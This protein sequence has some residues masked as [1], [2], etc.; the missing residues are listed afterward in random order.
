MLTVTGL[1]PSIRIFP[2][3]RLIHMH[4]C[5]EKTIFLVG[6]PNVGKS[7]IFNALTGLREHT[8]N[9]S[10][11][12]ARLSRG[13]FLY[14]DGLYH[15]VDLPGVYSLRTLSPEEAL[16]RS[17]LVHDRNDGIVLVADATCLERNL[18][19]I[20]QVLSLG[21]N[22][23]LCLNLMDEARKRGIQIDLASLAEQLG[24]PVLAASAKTGEGLEMLLPEIKA[25]C[26]RN[27][28]ASE[29]AVSFKTQASLLDTDEGLAPSLYEKAA[30]IYR[31][32]VKAKNEGPSS[33]DLRL[34]RLLTRPLTAYPFMAGLL[35]LIFWLT[36]YGANLPSE[37]LRQLFSRGGEALCL[38]FEQ[39]NAPWWLKGALTEGVY[40]TLTWVVS[41]MLP[42]MVIF[43]P[44]FSLL[45]DAGILPRI[46]FTMDHAFKKAGVQGKQCL[47]ACMGFGCN[48]CAVTGCRI[49][50][51][52]RERLIAILT[53]VFVPCNGRFPP[54]YKGKENDF[55]A[56]PRK[57]QP[58][59]SCRCMTLAISCMAA[60]QTPI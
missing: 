17:V 18:F 2:D 50:D 24:I 51:S 43:F 55:Q 16:T 9:W 28:K 13:D 12:T 6:N 36:I 1:L 7:T 26:E 54:P 45:E 10:G 15:L 35:I 14:E 3:R 52:Q 19:L 23:F 53:N 22:A 42:P 37:L 25:L 27:A 5:Q 40:Q 20:L 59:S 33:K 41:V 39:I 48:A 32:C 57:K 44:L 8:G 31:S 29:E 60:S 30:R 34:D 56:L 47:T 58:D 38:F 11:K 21:F 49:I 4:P 46:A